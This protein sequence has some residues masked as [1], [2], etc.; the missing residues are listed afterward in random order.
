[1]VN[2]QEYINENYPLEKR[3]NI[4][5]LDLNNKN[6]EGSLDLTTFINLRKLNVSFNKLNDIGLSNS[7]LSLK[8]LNNSYNRIP[9]F[10][11]IGSNLTHLDITSN[12]LTKL[13][14]HEASNLIELKCSGNPITNLSLPSNPSPNFVDCSILPSINNSTSFSLI[15]PIALGIVAVGVVSVGGITYYLIIR[16]KRE[17]IRKQISQVAEESGQETKSEIADLDCALVIS[18]KDGIIG[19]SEYNLWVAVYEPSFRKV[20]QDINLIKFVKKLPVIKEKL[21]EII[22]YFGEALNGDHPAVELYNNIYTTEL[23]SLNQNYKNVSKKEI[24]IPTQF[25]PDDYIRP[26]DIIKRKIKGTLAYHYAIYLGNKQVVHI[27]GKE[28]IELIQEHIDIAE[29]VRYGQ[30]KYKLFGNNCEHFATMCVYGLGMSQQAKSVTG[31]AD[32]LL[33]V[34]EEN[35][36]LFEELEKNHLN[37]ESES[38]QSIEI[39]NQRENVFHNNSTSLLSNL[40]E[41][42]D[43]IELENLSLQAQIEVNSNQNN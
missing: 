42:N 17:K 15:A 38:N 31:K 33:K 35:N 20:K 10:G 32:Y 4:T 13:D 41:T 14:V 34:I 21:G 24:E 23:P 28:V 9:S 1:M 25:E 16:K 6:L 3:A 19:N 27:S 12:N 8:K 5:E 43:D 22:K 26:Y 18:R 37:S 2:A 30:G 36:K 29:K 40:E 39:Y 11:F 7:A